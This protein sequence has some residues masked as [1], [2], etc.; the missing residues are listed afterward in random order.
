MPSL[1]SLSSLLFL[2]F[3]FPLIIHAIISG[4]GP[5]QTG[6]FAPPVITAP[7]ITSSSPSATPSATFAATSTCDPP[8]A[9]FESYCCSGQLV[10]PQ[11]TGS[12][13]GSYK[14]TDV[15]TGGAAKAKRSE[16]NGI[17]RSHSIPVLPATALAPGVTCFGSVATVAAMTGGGNATTSV[18]GGSGSSST[19]S[20]SSVTSSE[21]ESS[22]VAAETVSSS[23]SSS[24]S[25]AVGTTGAGASG[26]A[27]TA[28]TAS[29]GGAAA[30]SGSGMIGGSV[31]G[32]LFGMAVAF[33]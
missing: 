33:L 8:A 20:V 12:P 17:G 18:A 23:A 25:G 5:V 6:P 9:L 7:S 2:L 21:S 3:I 31:L 27:S 4:P 1:S 28:S 32:G 13:Q 15:P 10:Y 19:S 11:P 26:P 14:T 16:P 24:S 29:T 30:G 22:S